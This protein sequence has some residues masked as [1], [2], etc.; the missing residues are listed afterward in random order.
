[1]KLFFQLK[2]DEKNAA[3]SLCIDSIIEAIQVGE[4]EVQEDED[5]EMLVEAIK[6]FE[7]MSPADIVDELMD[8]D[9]GSAELLFELGTLKAQE[10]FF[11]E[12]NESVMFIPSLSEGEKETQQKIPNSKLN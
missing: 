6:E 1:M 8:L 2:E 3:V 4:F 12:E 10:T 7:G 9:N 11:H 5:I